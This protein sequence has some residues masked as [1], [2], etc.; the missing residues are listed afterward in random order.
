VG[1]AG[2]NEIVST[3]DIDSLARGYANAQTRP[4]GSWIIFVD[5]DIILMMII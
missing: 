4:Y 5:L 1:K 3:N 2:F